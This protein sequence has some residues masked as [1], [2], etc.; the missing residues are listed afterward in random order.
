MSNQWESKKETGVTWTPTKGADGKA[1]YEATEDDYLDG[2]YVGLKE[3]VGKNNQNVYSIETKEGV[4][5]EVW[6]TTLIKDQFQ[7]IPIGSYV[8]IK[9]NGMK[10]TKE[11][12]KLFSSPQEARMN[13][14]TLMCFHDFEVF[15]DR[16]VPLLNS[17]GNT[18]A[19]T[20]TAAPIQNQP[21][22]NANGASSFPSDD[23]PFIMTLLFSVG[24]IASMMI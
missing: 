16:S 21:V 20:P 2:Y 1:R 18:L 3:N 11:G 23:L 12:A 22:V 4:K 10:L 14:Q 15:V 5:K 13:G 19:P 17:G 9:W 24:S 8:R 6:G 7:T